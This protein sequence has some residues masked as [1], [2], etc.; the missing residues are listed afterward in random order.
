[1]HCA[2]DL[3]KKKIYPSLFALYY[4]GMLPPSTMIYGYARS[5]MSDDA[6]RES[7]MAMLPC[8]LN[9]AEDCSRKM[10]AFMKLCALPVCCMC[11]AHSNASAL[12]DSN[13][14]PQ[15]QMRLLTPARQESHNSSRV[16]ASA[17]ASTSAGSTRQAR[18]LGVCQTGWPRTRLLRCAFT[19]VACCILQRLLLL[20]FA[21]RMRSP[22]LG[23]SAGA[24]NSHPNSTSKTH[25]TVH[26]L[27]HSSA[28]C[29][30]GRDVRARPHS[31]ATQAVSRLL[32]CP[33]SSACISVAAATW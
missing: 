24:I 16:S 11:Q 25:F 9:D 10:D 23:R 7:I 32:C 5:D 20:R 1:M 31:C 19:L 30:E 27:P 8:R 18:T 28:A 17:G 14:T 3:A 12:L 2:G 6:F 22:L 26:P 13:W 15:G 29:H 21:A 33:R 4:Q